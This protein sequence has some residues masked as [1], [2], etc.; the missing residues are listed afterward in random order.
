MQIFDYHFV[1]NN[2]E[3]KYTFAWSDAKGIKYDSLADAITFNLKTVIG[4][5]SINEDTFVIEYC[6]LVVSDTNGENL[7]KITPV[8]VYR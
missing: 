1:I 4:G 2:N 7:K 8:I 3:M 5:V 6:S